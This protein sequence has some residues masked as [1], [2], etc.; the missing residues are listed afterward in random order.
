MLQFLPRKGEL[1]N[2][3]QDDTYEI[4]Q[5]IHCAFD[6]ADFDAEVWAVRVDL[7][8]KREEDWNRIR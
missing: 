1:I 6:D 4:V 2:L 8:K 3:N 7:D 5:V